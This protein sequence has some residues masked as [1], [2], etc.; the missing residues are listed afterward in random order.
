MT[1]NLDR[2]DNPP[3][4]AGSPHSAMMPSPRPFGPTCSRSPP[5]RHSAMRDGMCCTRSARSRTRSSGETS[6]LSSRT[7]P[8]TLGVDWPLVCISVGAASLRSPRVRRIG[9]KPRSIGKSR[10]HEN[11]AGDTRPR[12]HDVRPRYGRARLRRTWQ[13]TSRPL[14]PPRADRSGT[15][16][17]PLACR[18]RMVAR[19]HRRARSGVS[20]RRWRP[21]RRPGSRLHGSRAWT[22]SSPGDFERRPLPRRRRA[23]DVTERLWL[24]EAGSPE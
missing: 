13:G 17:R 2:R 5:R 24:E 16:R 15:P 8:K 18:C 6:P 22:R 9:S 14:L 4:H 23:F 21:R 3:R 7:S 19:S 1:R 10:T 20:S 11:V 12:D